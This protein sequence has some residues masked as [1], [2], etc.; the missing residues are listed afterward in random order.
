M[1]GGY[2]RRINN[3][4]IKKD[5]QGKLILAIFLSGLGGCLSIILLL[6]LFSVDTL[7]ISYDNNSIQMGQTPLMLFKNALA[8]NWV[9]MLIGGTF[10][11]LAAMVGTHRIAGPLFRLEKALNNMEKGIL[12]DHIFLR[13]KD[14]GK[15]LA[16]QLNSFN[17]TLVENLLLIKKHSQAIDD[18]IKQYELSNGA[19]ISHEEIQAI[20]QSIKV[21]N[22]KTQETL[23]FYTLTD[24]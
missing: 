5:L 23:D 2:K 13:K 3:F 20:C 14:E 11:V 18:L 9:F 12:N 8:A 1:S 15:D 19:A 4:F 17:T 21:K 16:R 24:D 10:L 6:A 22:N 7:T